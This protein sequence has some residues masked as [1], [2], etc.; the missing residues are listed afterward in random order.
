MYNR[1]NSS[2]NE[3][4]LLNKGLNH[5]VK[6]LKYDIKQT[7]VDIESSIKYKPD[8]VK[9]KIRNEVKPI[10]KKIKNMRPKQTGA[11]KTIKSLREKDVFYL[12]ADKGNK[13]VIMDKKDYESKI[14]ELINESNCIN[15][16]KDP[17]KQMVT[18]S[19]EMIKKVMVVFQVLSWTLN[20]SNPVLPRLYGLPK[21]HKPILKMR[22]I[23][24]NINAPAYKLAKWLVSKFKQLHQPTGKDVKNSLDF[25]DRI[26]NVK[27]K[28]DEI[29]VSFDVVSLYPSIPLRMAIIAIKNKVKRNY[30]ELK[31]TLW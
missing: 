1:L 13:L 11:F 22:P 8:S 17:L 31:S 26:K 18:K 4:S 2:E 15:L 12:K 29:M 30:S 20:V 7:I 23:V 5:A 9:T 3:L 25:V 27:L 6:P 19:K 14:E 24:S 16:K 10:I 28:E 21:I